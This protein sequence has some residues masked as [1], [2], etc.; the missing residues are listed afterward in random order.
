LNLQIKYLFA[1]KKKLTKKWNKFYSKILNKNEV[2]SQNIIQQIDN[3]KHF[4]TIF[5][6]QNILEALKSTNLN[7]TMGMDLFHGNA[8]K[9]KDIKNNVA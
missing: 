7:K 4:E 3:F 6:I 2:F 9:Y 1:T 5:E 8:L